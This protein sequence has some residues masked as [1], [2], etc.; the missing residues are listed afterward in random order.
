MRTIKEL[1]VHCTATP[2]GKFFDAADIDRWHKQRGW[3]GNGYHFVILL[4]GTIEYG[5]DLKKSGAHT[6]G[7]NST[8]IGIT[9]IGGMDANMQ[10]AKDTRTEA[11]KE[12][13]LLLLKTLKKLHP[14]AVIYGHRDFSSKACPS[15]DAKTEYEN[16]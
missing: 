12:S 13:M 10:K 6:R 4:D 5:R 16:L 7:R 9:Y 15:F 1:I 8:S 11:Q 14:E 3:S 2:Q